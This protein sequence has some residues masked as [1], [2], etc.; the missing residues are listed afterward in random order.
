MHNFASGWL[1]RAAAVGILL[2]AT[3]SAEGATILVRAGD[4]L[5]T[6]LNAAQPG[7]T[8]LL[9]AGA[10]FTGNF[11]LPVKTGTPFITVRSSIPD[12]QAPGA[13]TRIAPSQAHLL[14][15]IRSGNTMPALRTAAGAH[16]WRLLLLEFSANREGFG[17][18]IQ[19]GDGSSA[20]NLS[21]QVPFALE[22]DRLYIHGD[23]VMGQKRGIAL[24][25]AAVTIRNC[26]IAGIRAVGMDTQA[27]GGWNGP[28]P[29]VIENNYLE[30]AG[31]NIMLGG[32]DPFITNL[33]SE[34]VVIRHNYMSRPMAWRDPVVPTPSGLSAK[35]AGTGSLVAGV[36]AYRVVAQT[37][38]SGGVI[39]RSAASAEVSAQAVAGGAIVLTW[40][41]VPYATDYQVYRRSPLGASHYW[42][43]TNAT[44]T[45]A[46]AAGQAGSAPT[47]PG[48]VWTVKNILE[49][50]NARGVLIEHNVF[51]NN[52]AGGQSG[53]ALMFTPRNQ[54]GACSWCVVEDVTFQ[55]NVV[56][57]SSGGINILG[58]DD[59]ASSRQTRN[60]R[61][62][63]NLF[64]GI[65][66]ALGGGAWFL[67]VGNGPADIVVDHNT[68][69]ANGTTVSYVYGGSGGTQIPGFQFTNNAVRHSDYG[70]NGADGAFGNG[71]IS[72][73]FPDGVV[74]GN[75]LQGGPSSRYPAENYFEGT[76]ASGFTDAAASDFTAA[77]GGPLYGRAT[78]GTNIGADVASLGPMIGRIVTGDMGR[79][80]A[81]SNLRMITR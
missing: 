35:A 10:T 42:T 12:E 50:K 58:Y 59:L 16:H 14:A 30:A 3:A 56:R 78:D 28:G 80:L 5:Q 11:V 46:G 53:W 66:T 23:P 48:S 55:R 39:A 22:L 57:H 60:I 69:D 43:V 2:C 54:D 17:E 41:P 26:Y 75:W 62:S 21:S 67:L 7:D 63:H 71:I 37:R 68:V 32:A 81:P 9:E 1:P 20:Q 49:L 74:R 45:D 27:I 51:E 29:F 65:T 76:F 34:N 36:H 25:A 6:A 72:M 4:N 18:I 40:T 13:G 73:Y 24:N 61:I 19:L 44:F 31:E 64:Y 79:V 52:W 38:V 47:S 33:V 77:P 15:T 70:M 8:L